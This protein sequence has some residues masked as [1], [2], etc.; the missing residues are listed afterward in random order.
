VV[1]NFLTVLSNFH[2]PQVTALQTLVSRNTS[3]LEAAVASVTKL[4]AATNAYNVIPAH[5]YLGGTLRCLCPE[6]L[7]RLRQRAEAVARGVAA[8]H[9]CA[10]DDITFAPDPYLPTINDPALWRDFVAPLVASAA[11]SGAATEVR[12]FSSSPYSVPAIFEH[13]RSSPASDRYTVC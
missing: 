5:V 9:D 13:F 12:A 11:T 2:A 7:A 10:I 6:G 3:P 1:V 8:A 4:Q